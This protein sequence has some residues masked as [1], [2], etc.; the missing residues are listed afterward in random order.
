[1]TPQ[2]YKNN[3]LTILITRKY[4]CMLQQKTI[5]PSH[6]NNDENATY[7]FMFYPFYKF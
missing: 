1:M 2:C 3:F 7:L 4:A 5:K 6:E